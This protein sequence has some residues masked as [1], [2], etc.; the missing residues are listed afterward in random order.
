[1]SIGPAKAEETLSA[2]LAMGADRAV[3][4]ETDDCV[5]PLAVAK[6]LKGVA[7][8]EQ[9]GLIIVG[10]QAIDDDSN[11]TDQMLSALLGRIVLTGV[12]GCGKSAV[13]AALAASIGA[14]CID[15]DDLH[16]PINVA[17]DELR[18]TT[19]RR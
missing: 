10:K 19:H 16:P 5:E 6:I 13:G 9:P 11:Q 15:G 14:T 3:L 17:K 1:M 18:R 4:V 12:A 2:A 7:E 8:A